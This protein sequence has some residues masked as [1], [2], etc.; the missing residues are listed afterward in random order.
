M[1]LTAQLAEGAVLAMQQPAGMTPTPVTLN[2]VMYMPVF[3]SA[4]P[5]GQVRAPSLSHPPKPTPKPHP[6]GSR[7]V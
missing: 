7:A 3:T 4:P 1:Q 5:G 2:G 6:F